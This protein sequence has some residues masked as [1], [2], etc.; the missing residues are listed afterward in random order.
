MTMRQL[1]K[2][3]LS[4]RTL[5]SGAAALG[6]TAA[7]PEV[8]WAEELTIWQQMARNRLLRETNR[9]GNTALALGAIDTPEPILALDTAY[10]LELAAR[11]Y[12]QIVAA[13]G[14]E[15][16][17]REIYQLVVG[18]KRRAVT[19][20]K[21]RLITMGDLAQGTRLH[22]TFDSETDIALR[23]FQ[24]RHGL[25]V[26]GKVGE[27]TFFALAVPADYRLNQ[28]RLNIKRIATLAPEIADQQVVVNIPAAVIEAMDAGQVSQRHTAIVGRIDRPTPILKSRIHQINFNPYWHVPKSLIRR[29]LIRYMNEDPNYLSKYR[30]HIY[31]HAG[32][33]LSPSQIDWSTDDA[34]QYAFRQDPG[35]ENS[36]GHVKI[37]FNN[38]YSVYLHD[39]PAKSLF[40]ENRRFNSSGCVRVENVGSFVEWILRSNS[41]WDENAIQAVFNSNERLDVSV[42]RPVPILTTYITAWAN[43][44]GVV[45]FRDDVYAFDAE[46]RIDLSA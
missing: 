26:D 3:T 37:N 14:W 34:V 6:A 18:V 31:D 27:D 21:R 5:L 12:E 9:G 30:I 19:R 44:A 41:G 22:D 33:E 20:L 16:M 23:T 28:L 7:L 42:S 35:A 36:M 11:K 38:P 17:P 4:R 29:D 25:K 2:N 1:S 39:T 40:G 13:G 45:S 46:G 43:R 24:A 15:E 8:A 10:S 32:R